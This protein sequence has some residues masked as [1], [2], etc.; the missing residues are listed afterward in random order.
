M[1]D[2]SQ[3]IHDEQQEHMRRRASL[4]PHVEVTPFK[5]MLSGIPARSED[6][7]SLEEGIAAAAQRAADKRSEAMRDAFLAVALAIVR[8]GQNPATDATL[9]DVQTFDAITRQLI[10]LER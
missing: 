1:S 10:A 9:M 3:A 6:T 2:E 7:P 5:R 4:H 8:R